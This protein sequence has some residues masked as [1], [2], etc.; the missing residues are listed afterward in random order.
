VLRADSLATFMCRLSENREKLNLLEVS[1]VDVGVCRDS[2]T[3]T[4]VSY[5]AHFSPVDDPVVG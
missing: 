1:G 5:L 3:V 4:P 2:F